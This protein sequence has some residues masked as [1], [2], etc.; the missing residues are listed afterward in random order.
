MVTESSYT[1][2]RGSRQWTRT[3][4]AGGVMNTRSVAKS[5][6]LVRSTGVLT[7]TA[8]GRS[9][10]DYPGKSGEV[11]EG[12]LPENLQ[13]NNKTGADILFTLW[14]GFGS[15]IDGQPDF[16]GSVDITSSVPIAIGASPSVLEMTATQAVKNVAAAGTPVRLTAG[17]VLCE[18]VKVK[19]RTANAGTVFLGYTAGVG[20]QLWE[21]VPTEWMQIPS[22]NGKRINLKNI[23]LDAANNG[24]GVVY[25]GLS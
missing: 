16:T 19:A 9:E 12:E 3:L 22:P 17:D 7:I 13:I 21:L 18:T 2:P 15:Y 5:F 23:W 20:T 11:F 1:G 6:Y 8:E 14:Y 10:Q 25:E 24:D 4:V